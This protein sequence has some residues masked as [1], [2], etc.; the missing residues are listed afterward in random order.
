MAPNNGSG[1]TAKWLW[2]AAFFFGWPILFR[3]VYLLVAV[4]MVLLSDR[5]VYTL[6]TNGIVMTALAWLVSRLTLDRGAPKSI[7]IPVAI[8]SIPMVVITVRETILAVANGSVLVPGAPLAI[9]G[10]ALMAIGPAVAIFSESR[11]PRIAAV[12]GAM[13]SVPSSESVSG[14]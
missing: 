13:P 2:L 4:F 7:W 6:V 9:A 12:D 1:K 5:F 14:T 3:V 10:L 8:S 11:R